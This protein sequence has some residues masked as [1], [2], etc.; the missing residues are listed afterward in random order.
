MTLIMLSPLYVINRFSSLGSAS[1]S[2]VLLTFLY[3]YLLDMLLLRPFSI[4]FASLFEARSNIK[5]N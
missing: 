3:S 5:S 4:F 1:L 2:T